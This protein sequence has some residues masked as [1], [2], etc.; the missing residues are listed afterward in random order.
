MAALGHS[1]LVR[2]VYD[3]THGSGQKAAAHIHAIIAENPKPSD[4]LVTDIIHATGAV[5]NHIAHNDKLTA[6]G[7]LAAILAISKDKPACALKAIETTLGALPLHQPSPTSRGSVRDRLTHD[8]IEHCVETA[9]FTPDEPIVC[10]EFII[11]EGSG[12]S[13]HRAIA[14]LGN[15][16]RSSFLMM[17]WHQLSFL[18]VTNQTLKAATFKG[19]TPTQEQSLLNRSFEALSKRAELPSFLDLAKARLDANAAAKPK[20]AVMRAKKVVM[21]GNKKDPALQ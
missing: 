5:I 7:L 10:K 14:L 16:R 6:H 3:I 17:N 4:E 2:T 12:Q 18:D 11:M 20:P 21:R 9:G 8:L 1:A 13:N 15:H 19:C